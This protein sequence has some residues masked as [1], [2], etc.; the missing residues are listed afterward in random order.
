M[1]PKTEEQFE[2]IR[3][4]SKA[5]I[6]QA[7][8]ELFAHNGFH[9]TTITQIAKEAG[10][11]KGLLYN[12]FKNKEDLLKQIIMEA[13]MLVEGVAIKLAQ[14][15][16]HPKAQLK[17]VIEESFDMVVANP[18]YWKLLTTV[19]LQTDVVKDFEEIF[20]NKVI[21]MMMMMEEIFKQLGYKDSKREAFLFGAII[22]GICFHFLQT[23]S[24]YPI[25]E[26]KA[27]VI[28]RYCE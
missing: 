19:S 22:D 15:S 9:S 28:K 13:L 27:F 25:A 7:G 24:L 8:L 20:K 10:I 26:M 23:G 14:Y 6:M 12:Y 3:K 18:Q 16:D 17:V 2:E 4:R 11:S 5:A 21:Q 1:S